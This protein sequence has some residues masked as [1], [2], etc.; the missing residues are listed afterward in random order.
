MFSHGSS[1]PQA[2]WTV[3]G[4]SIRLAQDVGAHRKKVYNPTRTVEEERWKRAFWS[5]ANADLPHSR[6][7]ADRRIL[8]VLVALDR[9]ISS[10]LGRPCAIHDEDFDLDLPIECDDEYWALED[11]KQA[12]KQPP[13]KPSAVAY[14]NCILRLNQILA[15][16]LR[17]IVRPS[18]LPPSSSEKAPSR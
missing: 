16:A 12:W 18:L 15:F 6:P 13:G 14:F 8:R 17:T 9:F 10:A 7:H 11:P 2:S 3:I 5:V 4:V 1:T